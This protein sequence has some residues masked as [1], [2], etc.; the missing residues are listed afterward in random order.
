[1]ATKMV[2][3]HTKLVND[4]LANFAMFLYMHKGMVMAKVQ[5]S[6]ITS[7]FENIDSGLTSVSRITTF[8]TV[9]P[10]TTL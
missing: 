2:P 9:S 3:M 8:V 5:I 6:T 10:T 7:L 4:M 1:M